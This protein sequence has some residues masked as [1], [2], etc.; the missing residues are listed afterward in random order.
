M[1]ERCGMQDLNNYGLEIY[2]KYLVLALMDLIADF[3]VE[4]HQPSTINHQLRSFAVEHK[5]I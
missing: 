1:V 4:V 2:I 5:P 3:V